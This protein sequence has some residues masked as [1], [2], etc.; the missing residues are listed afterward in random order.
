MF[1]VMRKRF[2]V[3][4][5]IIVAVVIITLSLFLRLCYIRVV[6]ILV[7]MIVVVVFVDFVHCCVVLTIPCWTVVVSLNSVMQMPHVDVLAHCRALCNGSTL[8]VTGPR[9]CN[10]WTRISGTSKLYMLALCRLSVT[11]E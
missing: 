2:T 8:S 3:V 4:V 10:S 11:I 7:P 1:E 5:V 6:I 9:T